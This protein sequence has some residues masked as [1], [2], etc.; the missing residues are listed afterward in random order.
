[1]QQ[2]KQTL[3]DGEAMLRSRADAESSEMQHFWPLVQT[4]IAV[5]ERLLALGVALAS[6]QK[7]RYGD[8]EHVVKSGHMP[9]KL[10]SA[11]HRLLE[12]QAEG[13]SHITVKDEACHAWLRDTPLK[14]LHPSRQALCG[15]ACPFSV[16][17][18]VDLY[19]T[20]LCVLLQPHHLLGGA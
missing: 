17:C 1:M 13:E 2:A 15:Y 19:L 8:A 9:S 3:A 18:S 20:G 7:G 6:P 5:K 10:L 16:S 4:Y 14:V 11:A 12:N